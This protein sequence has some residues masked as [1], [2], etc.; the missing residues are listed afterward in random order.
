MCQH[1]NAMN[2]HRLARRRKLDQIRA[3]AV[4][5]VVSLSILGCGAAIVPTGHFQKAITDP[6]SVVFIGD[7]ITADWGWDQMSPEF[8]EHPNWVDKGVSGQNSAQ[9][10]AR[11]QT[12]VIDLHPEIVHILVG[13]NDLYPGWTLGPS[14]SNSID[15]VANV[16]AMVRMAQASGIHVILATI[17]PWA[18][19]ASNC[20]LAVTVD[21]TSS[22]YGRINTWNAWIEQF[23]LSQGI[24]VADYHSALLAADGQRYVSDMTLDGIHPSEAGFVLMTPMVENIIG[25]ISSTYTGK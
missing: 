11:F 23:A 25:A 22:R 21:S 20:V 8:A 18:C 6:A 12:D 1:G 5:S 9:V 15:S 2:R 13:T 3:L 14:Q 24:P 4:L 16:E 17:P 19:S 7:S 10:L